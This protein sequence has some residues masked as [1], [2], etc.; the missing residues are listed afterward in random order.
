[1]IA[2]IENS[3]VIG[4]SET[5]NPV[6]RFAQIECPPETQIGWRFDGATFSPPPPPSLEPLKAAKRAAI[7]AKRDA[8]LAEGAPYG[9]KR[10][11]IDERGRTD[12][13]GMATT[14]NTVL[15]TAGSPSP[16]AWPADYA[17]GWIAKD[18]SRVP[19]P[20]PAAGLAL[21][22]ACGT[23]YA[24]AIQHARTLKDAAQAAEDQAELDL[25]D[26]EAGWP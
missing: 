8:V 11:E 22:F 15:L 10:I 14:A 16:V 2:F 3:A 7:N 24:A 18:N 13:G 1:M 21:A 23:F 4:L 25:I 20:T 26:L 5:R 17:L 6:E 19:L 12:L 9:G